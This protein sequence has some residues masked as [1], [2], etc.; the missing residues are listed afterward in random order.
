MDF[1]TGLS[2]STDCKGDSYDF[3]LV[4]V[5]WLTNMVH[6]KLIKI[7]IDAP[8]LAEIIIDVVVWHYGL[9]DSIVTDRSSL[10][11]TKFWSSLCYFLGIERLV[12]IVFNSQTDGQTER[13]NSTMKAYLKAFVNFS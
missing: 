7:T 11:T 12:S 10:F 6:Y 4:I 2:I 5:D 8:G 1:L 3:I 9:P 13:Q